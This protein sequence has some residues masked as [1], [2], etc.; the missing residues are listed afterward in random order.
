MGN[1]RQL[2]I[3]ATHYLRRDIAFNTTGVAGGLLIGTVPAGA[4]LT[5]VK[6]YVDEIFNAVSTN[7][8]VAGTTL[9]GTNLVAAADVTEGTI[10]VYTPANAANQGLG[11]VFAADTDL[12]VSYTQT[13]T[14]ATTGKATIVVE[15][16]PLSNGG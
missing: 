15:F 14:A 9:L 10:G 1:A 7:V 12:F 4:K 8:L 13:G 2:E 6:V 11:L 3:Q 5:N 16:V